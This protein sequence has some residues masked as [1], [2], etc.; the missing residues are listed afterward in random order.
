MAVEFGADSKLNWT[1]L[2]KEQAPTYID[3][4]EDENRRH[5]LAIREAR[6]RQGYV[7]EMSLEWKLWQSA[8]HRHVNDV[9]DTKTRIREVKYF[10]GMEE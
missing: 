4:L 10:F 1:L 9:E 8:I 7:K 2:N 5:Q 6:Y 3:F